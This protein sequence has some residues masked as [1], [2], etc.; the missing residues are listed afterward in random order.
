MI[1]P[2]AFALL[3]DAPKPRTPDAA[4]FDAL[5]RK[6]NDLKAFV[7]EYKV[8]IPGEAKE[9]SIRLAFRAPGDLRIEMTVPSTFVLQLHD[10]VLEA[11]GSPSGESGVTAHVPIE[12]FYRERREHLNEAVG[13]SFPEAKKDWVVE[14][15]CGATLELEVSPSRTDEKENFQFQASYS[16]HR[17][18][19]LG[20][21]E[22]WKSQDDVRYDGDDHLALTTERGAKLKLSTKTGF[23]ERIEKESK[24]ETFYF[25]LD[26]LDL[27][28]KFDAKAFALPPPE[29]NAQDASGPF[30]ARMQ[31]L[32]TLDHRAEVFRCI[33]RHVEDKSLAWNDDAKARARKVFERVHSDGIAGEAAS[34]LEGTKRQLDKLGDLLRDQYAKLPKSDGAGRSELDAKVDAHRKELVDRFRKFLEARNA[35]LSVSDRTVTDGALREDLGGIEKEAA[36][37]AF[38][39]VV[40]D[41]LLE[42]FDDEVSKAKG[43]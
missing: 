12:E 17:T 18:A 3:Q 26:S 10:G 13:A 20:W 1:A 16:C 6:T 14:P 39:H 23:V 35:S 28:P 31:H 15:E 5:I 33:A 37:A 8:K 22:F 34:L 7:A 29:K 21:L 38:A 24:G 25:Q 9:G 43:G 2:L 30:S 42:A 36:E 41:P 27:D 4:V 19:L 40:Q 11:A 32:I